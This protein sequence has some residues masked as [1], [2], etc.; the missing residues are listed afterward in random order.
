MKEMFMDEAV[1]YIVSHDIGL[2][3]PTQAV[4]NKVIKHF[5]KKGYKWGDGHDLSGDSNLPS[6]NWNHF[7]EFK[8]NTTI[9]VIPNEEHKHD[10]RIWCCP[11]D[12]CVKNDIEVIEL[13]DKKYVD[14]TMEKVIRGAKK[15]GNLLLAIK[16]YKYTEPISNKSL[17]PYI[18]VHEIVSWDGKDGHYAPNEGDWLYGFDGSTFPFSGLTLDTVDFFNDTCYRFSY[19]AYETIIKVGTTKKDTLKTITEAVKVALD[20]VE[21]YIQNEI[22]ENKK[23]RDTYREFLEEGGYSN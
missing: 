18:N 23:T 14:K 10:D 3:T 6:Y 9:R 1:D 4:Y 20:K 17:V 22:E 5:D 15:G 2:H 8:E 13:V 11:V 16:F 12:Y 21:E 7:K 19:Y